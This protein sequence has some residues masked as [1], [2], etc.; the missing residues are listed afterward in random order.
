MEHRVAY[1]LSGFY[2]ATLWSGEQVPFKVEHL[3]LDSQEFASVL[4]SPLQDYLHFGV[5]KVDYVYLLAY[6][7]EKYRDGDHVYIRRS[8]TPIEI[9]HGE[10]PEEL[11][12]LITL[13]LYY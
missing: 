3:Q 6:K 8:V 1:E 9:E 11:H 5:Q 10:L 2:V 7:Q 13:L 12:H 4:E